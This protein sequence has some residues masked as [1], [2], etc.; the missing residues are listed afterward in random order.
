MN[1]KQGAG[2]ANPAKFMPRFGPGGFRRL[3]HIFPPIRNTGVKV[4]RISADWRRWELRLPMSMKTRNYVGTHFGGTL[5][6]AADPHIMLAW[7]HIL[8]GWTVW[9][10]A[11]S[12][13]FR[14]PGKGTLRTS[15]E[16]DE[17][18]IAEIRTMAPGEKRD[19]QYVLEW[20][21]GEGD[22][23]ASVEKTVHIQAPGP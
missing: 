2:L 4:D 21:D 18:E 12:I 11:A 3:L 19:L 22:V 1:P 15:F 10:K 14:K 9:D 20:L 17:A 6:S 13:R 7:M 8:P 5:Y 23:V 16:I